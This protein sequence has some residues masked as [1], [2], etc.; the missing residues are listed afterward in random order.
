MSYEK[1]VQTEEIVNFDHIQEIFI[2]GIYCDKNF[3]INNRRLVKTNLAHDIKFT[4]INE[5]HV[6]NIENCSLIIECP[7]SE[8]QIHASFN[9]E[10]ENLKKIIFDGFG[11]FAEKPENW[12]YNHYHESYEVTDVYFSF[13][14][15]ATEFK[16]F[17]LEILE[18]ELTE[19]F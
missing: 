9:L 17:N 7:G 1:D 14:K 15:I 18:L 4:T 13:N 16:L 5:D 8:Y 10:A 6:F 3:Y 19:R 11:L 12:Q 2:L